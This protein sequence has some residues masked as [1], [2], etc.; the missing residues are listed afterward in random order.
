MWFQRGC[1]RLQCGQRLLWIGFGWIVN[2]GKRILAERACPSLPIWRSASW[3][4]WQLW[5]LTLT[6]ENPLD[7]AT[8]YYVAA[9]QLPT[10]T[11]NKAKLVKAIEDL[12]ANVASAAALALTET[13]VRAA[14]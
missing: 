11:P 2:R 6:Q 3:R 9:Q 7:F 10:L 8:A 12:G 4:L 1:M 5:W 13:H 14:L